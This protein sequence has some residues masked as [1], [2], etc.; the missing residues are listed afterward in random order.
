MRAPLAGI[1]A[2][3]ALVLRNPRGAECR[4]GGV[5]ANAPSASVAALAR[6]VGIA[7]I[8]SGHLSRGLRALPSLARRLRFDVANPRPFALQSTS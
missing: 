2:L 7:V 5:G 6:A 3:A 8:G 1:M 4:D